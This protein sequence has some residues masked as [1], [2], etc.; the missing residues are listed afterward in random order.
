VIIPESVSCCGFAG[1]RGFT[2]PELNASALH[3]LRAEL[4]RD[5]RSG[6]STS[7]TCEVGMSLHGGIPYQSVVYLVDE[8]TEPG[9]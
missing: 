3:G 7:R 1:D 6:Y 9:P 4:P 8:A 2:V 5:C